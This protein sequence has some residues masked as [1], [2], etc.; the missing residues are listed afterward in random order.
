MGHWKSRHRSG[1][2]EAARA[3]ETRCLAL[4]CCPCY[5]VLGSVA[6][7]VARCLFVACYP[8]IQCCG[9]DECRHHHHA[10]NFSHFR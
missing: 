8:V 6:R 7:G 9:L 5:Y 1:R 3:K 2:D 4:A 10:S